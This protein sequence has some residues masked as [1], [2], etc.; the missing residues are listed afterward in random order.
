MVTA[1][2]AGDPEAAERPARADAQALIDAFKR[3]L[4]DRPIDD[5]ALDTAPRRP[6]PEEAERLCT[7][8]VYC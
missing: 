5:I 8:G 3:N 4:S 2:A 6:L 7:R 1:I